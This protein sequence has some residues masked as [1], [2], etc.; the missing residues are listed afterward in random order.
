M[1]YAVAQEQ[2]R[3]SAGK[4]RFANLGHMKHLDEINDVLSNHLHGERVLQATQV[5]LEESVGQLGAAIRLGTAGAARDDLA[6]AFH[7]GGYL[8]VTSSRVF[9]IGQTA[10]KAR[11]KDLVFTVDRSALQSERGTKRLMGLIKLDTLTL[12]CEEFSITFHIPKNARADG[13]AV[14]EQLGAS[15]ASP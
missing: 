6:G 5:L 15:V 11:P 14:M 13:Q 9:A 12:T 2:E 8:A 3:C 10:V 7:P 1:M 4:D